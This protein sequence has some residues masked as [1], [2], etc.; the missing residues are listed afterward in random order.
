MLPDISIMFICVT[1][2][3]SRR[4]CSNVCYALLS[5]TSSSADLTTVICDF[6]SAVTNAVKTSLGTHVVV[7]GCFF[8]LCQSTWHKVQDL[9]LVQSYKSCENVLRQFVNMI[10]VFAYLLESDVPAEP[11]SLHQHRSTLSLA[12]ILRRH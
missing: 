11:S 2:G 4:H 10:D 1:L 12:D 3:N 8:H 9:G 7:K 5:P 6:E